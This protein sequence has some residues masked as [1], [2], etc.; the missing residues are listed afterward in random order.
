MREVYV[1]DTAFLLT[2]VVDNYNTLI[3]TERYG[4]VSEFVMTIK[5]TMQNRLELREGLFLTLEGSIEKMQIETQVAKHGLLTLTGYG[6]TNILKHRFVRANWN[7]TNNFYQ[8]GTGTPGQ[9]AAWVVRDM[10]MSG[11]YNNSNGQVAGSGTGDLLSYL[12]L[13]LL[14]TTKGTSEIRT[15]EFG[16]IFDAVKKLCSS[17]DL[18]FTLYHTQ[19]GV[20]TYKL[21]FTTY[22][23]RDL[24]SAQSTYPTV[25]FEPAM[26]NLAD[27][28]ELRS[29]AGYRNAAVAYPATKS[30][31]YSLYAWAYMAD[32]NTARNFQRRTMMVNASDINL[33]A[34]N[35]TE[36]STINALLAVRAKEALIN[37]NYVKM[38][39]GSL[40]PQPGY[41]YGVDYKMGDI[42]EL[43]TRAGGASQAR[44]SE[45]IRAIDENGERAYPTLTVIE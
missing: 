45:Y 42:I 40:V 41:V 11:A 9:Q 7:S 24:T 15:V 12:E 38:V 27:P 2:R 44:V 21:T 37:N 1:L 8:C 32:G 16:P 10:L 22:A 31:T 35:A 39:D 14:D 5:D 17:E 18:G 26:E 4:D 6:L 3:W 36:A 28:K 23:G 33:P 25:R 19:T 13:G 29:I 34:T 30:A 20:A 43:R